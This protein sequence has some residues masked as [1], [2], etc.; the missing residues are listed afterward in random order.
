ME[1][2]PGCVFE[3]GV[4]CEEGCPDV[5]RRR[6][7]PEVVGVDRFV[8]SMADL[9]AGV[10]ELR[11]GGQQ[12]VADG[13]DR[14]R[15]DRLLQS[16]APLGSPASDQR[17]VAELGNGGGGEE[18]LEA[19]M[20]RTCVSN[21][22]RRRRLMDA[23]KTPVSTRILT[24]RA[25]LRTRRLRPRTA[26]RSTEGRS[27]RAPVPRRADGLSDRRAATRSRAEPRPRVER[28]R[29]RPSAYAPGR[30]SAS[31]HEGHDDVGGVAVEVLPTPVHLACQRNLLAHQ[32]AFGAAL[33][34]T[35]RY[36]RVTLRACQHGD[37]VP[38][39][40]ALDDG[41]PL[42]LDQARQGVRVVEA[43]EA[44]HALVERGA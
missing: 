27:S 44:G 39:A 33:L 38:V 4:G 22:A 10:A 36:R 35:S 40:V 5:D 19:A 14:G 21:R 31:G 37:S 28:H 1:G 11:D 23:L 7:D 6:S 9:S 30:R 20:R 26:P 29:S 34:E 25:L 32:P 2:K 16:V 8:Q 24:T 13:H 41:Q 42:G 17:A 15:F 12:S 43:D 3:D 18:D